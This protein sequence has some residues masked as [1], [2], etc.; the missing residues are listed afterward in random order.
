[1]GTV[2]AWFAVNGVAFLAG[3]ATMFAG[4]RAAKWLTKQFSDAQSHIPSDE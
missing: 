2:V 1:M 3:A 4:G